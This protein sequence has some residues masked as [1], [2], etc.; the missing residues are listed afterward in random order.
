MKEKKK[1]LVDMGTRDESECIG[2]CY[3]VK[4]TEFLPLFTDIILTVH[5]Y[6][7]IEDRSQGADAQA[8]LGT[9]Q[10]TYTN[11]SQL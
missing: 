7:K 2:T 4:T 9:Y 1:T 6:V 11:L 5:F 3:L 8:P 10:C